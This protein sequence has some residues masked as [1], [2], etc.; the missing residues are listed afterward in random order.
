MA[1][2]GLCNFYYA[3]LLQ[4]NISAIAGSITHTIVGIISG[5]SVAV[6]GATLVAGTGF[7]PG[8]NDMATA[9]AL[10]TSLNDNTTFN[11]KYTAT[12]SGNVITVT[13]KVAGGGNTPG[14]MVITGTG[15][16]TNGT[17][18]TSLAA[19]SYDTAKKI[20][21]AITADIKRNGSGTP[22]YAD[23]GVF[24]YATGKGETEVTLDAAD[25][26]LE[27]LATILG[28]TITN[29]VMIRKSTDIPPYIG[30]AF[31]GLMHNNKREFVKLLKGVA[32]IEDS[33]MDTNAATPKFNTQKLI[34][35]FINRDYDKAS[36]KIAR[37]DAVGYESTTGDNWYE[38]FEEA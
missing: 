18:V 4:D 38:E 19:I 20:A 16:C 37:E 8:A 23:N 13:E 36:E 31:E 26:S 27:D 7:T 14:T 11:A 28:H 33:T 17:P 30:I 3:K 10:V 24:A 21:G 2:K 29:G 1:F 6:D 12:S 22:L 32:R 25:I 15:T 9:L 35:D 5:D 34:I